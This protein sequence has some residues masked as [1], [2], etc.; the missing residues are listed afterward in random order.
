M[1]EA[2]QAGISE[3]QWYQ[4]NMQAP[5]PVQRQVVNTGSWSLDGKHLAPTAARR[6]K[7]GH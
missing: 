5:Y 6:V 3:A 1:K 4:R 2:R 7:Q